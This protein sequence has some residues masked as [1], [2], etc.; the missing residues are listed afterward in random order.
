MDSK[1][2]VAM[3]SEERVARMVGAGADV[4]N[5]VFEALPCKNGQ[6]DVDKIVALV[7]AGTITVQYSVGMGPY[8]KHSLLHWAAQHANSSVLVEA[9]LA[10]GADVSAT[11]ARGRVPWALAHRV[12]DRD[13][14]SGRVFEL[15]DAATPAE[16]K[17]EPPS[18]KISKMKGGGGLQQK[19]K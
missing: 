1:Y 16:S 19:P 5:A 8:A 12:K 14:L 11:D 7:D 2:R 18:K 4:G 15:V 17:V 6:A 10:R 3:A 13:A 9:L